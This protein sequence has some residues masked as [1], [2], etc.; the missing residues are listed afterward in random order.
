[1]H[2]TPSGGS[3]GFSSAMKSARVSPI[4]EY[5][6]THWQCLQVKAQSGMHEIVATGEERENTQVRVPFS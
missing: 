4:L 2:S 3:L 6:K 5:V 1:M